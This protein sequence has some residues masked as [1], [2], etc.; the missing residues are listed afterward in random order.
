MASNG[1]PSGLKYNYANGF[2]NHSKGRV[3]KKEKKVIFITLGS[4]PPPSKVITI[5]LATRHLEK[6]QKIGVGKAKCQAHC[7]K[8]WPFQAK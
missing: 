8:C 4:V 2:A 7:P 1:G 5:F 3:Q 6:F